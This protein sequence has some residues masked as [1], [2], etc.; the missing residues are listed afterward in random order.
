MATGVQ[1]SFQPPTRSR[2]HPLYKKLSLLNGEVNRLSSEEVR[3]KLKDIG[4]SD[5]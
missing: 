4:L 2:S 3:K 1:K 5:K